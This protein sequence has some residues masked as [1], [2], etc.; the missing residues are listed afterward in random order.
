MSDSIM[1]E[2]KKMEQERRQKSGGEPS[3][4]KVHFESWFN[5]RKHVIPEI[6][7]K[8][9]LVA[10]FKSRGLGL[11]ASMEEFDR[12]LRLYGVKF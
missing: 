12:A 11:E 9:V 6:H 4:R 10:D 5:Q 7:K 3:Q 2:I 1:K 8:E